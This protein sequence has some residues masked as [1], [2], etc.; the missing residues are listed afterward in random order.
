ME[1]QFWPHNFSSFSIIFGMNFLI[2]FYFSKNSHFLRVL[3]YSFAQIELTAV[4][5]PFRQLK[6]E[7]FISILL[8]FHEKSFV[9][10]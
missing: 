1:S 6:N 5:S 3:Q 9:S 7:N 4:K 8:S 10:G 2:N